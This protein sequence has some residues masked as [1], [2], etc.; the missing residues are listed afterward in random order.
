M[1]NPRDLA[2]RAEEAGTI[3]QLSY[4]KITQQSIN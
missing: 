4:K 3:K 1:V 2:G